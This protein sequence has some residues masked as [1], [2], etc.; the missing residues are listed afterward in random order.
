MK[1]E[2]LVATKN[3][4]KLKEIKEI[5]KGL[6]FRVTSLS[7]YA[8]APRIIENGKSFMENAIKKA[9]QTARFANKL[10]L[11]ED[12]GLCV[13]ALNGAPGINS[14]RFS[15][16][17]KSDR[18]NNLKLLKMLEG[19]PLK[20]RKAHYIAAVA[21]ADQNGL[22]AVVEGSCFGSIGYELKGDS[23]FGYDPLF[24]IPKYKKTFAEL[25]SRIKHRMSHR[26]RALEKVKLRLAIYLKRNP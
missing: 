9:A 17:N 24:I 10:T 7:S 2:L 23:G 8:L 4:K 25:G 14:A 15:G 22:L 19:L 16:K 21:L 13:D 5:L 1:R 11:G 3:K 18:Q 6:N 12:S 26:F 20:K